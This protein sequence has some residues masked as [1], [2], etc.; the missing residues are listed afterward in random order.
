[1][2]CSVPSQPN[3][4][5]YSDLESDAFRQKIH[6]QYRHHFYKRMYGLDF[7]DPWQLTGELD[8]TKLY[9]ADRFRLAEVKMWVDPGLIW[10]LAF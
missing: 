1:M 7:V 6:F 10:G 4:T 8:L 9:S 2:Q 3:V 5:K